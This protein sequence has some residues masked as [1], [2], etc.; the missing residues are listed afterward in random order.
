MF[1][2]L[3]AAMFAISSNPAMN[4][5]YGGEPREPNKQVKRGPDNAPH[6]TWEPGDVLVKERRAAA[7]AELEKQVAIVYWLGDVELA[8]KY[9]TTFP[10]KGLT[11]VEK[12]RWDRTVAVYGAF[13]GRLTEVIADDMAAADESF[14]EPAK[15]EQTSVENVTMPDPNK[16]DDTKPPAEVATKR[17]SRG[18]SEVF[19]ALVGR[20][21]DTAKDE[22]RRLL[23]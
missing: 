7:D 11:S 2:S 21:D 20:L 18:E 9:G 16:Q 6:F 22:L 3:V 19:K 13:M 10:A 8:A 4:G 5:V 23:G 14:T 15:G 17:Q 1:P 12:E